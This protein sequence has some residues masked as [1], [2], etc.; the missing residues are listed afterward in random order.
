MVEFMPDFAAIKAAGTPT[1]IAAGDGSLSG[2]YCYVRVARAMAGTLSCPL[3]TFPG[4]HHAYE[5]RPDAFAQSL[6]RVIG[7]LCREA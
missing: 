4:H 1:V 7:Q 2:E 3:V 6:A 5:D